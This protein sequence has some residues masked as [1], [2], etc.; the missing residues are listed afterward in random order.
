MRHAAGTPA[1]G[2]R[3]LRVLSWHGAV[4]G[5]WDAVGPL[6]RLFKTGFRD[7]LSTQVDRTAGHHV[8]WR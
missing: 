5:Y 2:T 7:E 8:A 1:V 3:T 4:A 6:H